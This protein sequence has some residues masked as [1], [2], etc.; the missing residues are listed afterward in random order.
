M[1][2]TA[3]D[4]NDPYLLAGLKEIGWESDEEVPGKGPSGPRSQATELRFGRILPRCTPHRS[5]GIGRSMVRLGPGTGGDHRKLIPQ[6]DGRATRGSPAVGF[7]SKGCHCVPC[8]SEPQQ[9][10]CSRTNGKQ[11][12]PAVGNQVRWWGFEQ[13]AAA[14]SRRLIPPFHP[15]L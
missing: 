1:E 8:S 13:H 4:F 5:P 12:A 15:P 11:H 14:G 10:S 6:V 3:E 7:G 2:L 9:R